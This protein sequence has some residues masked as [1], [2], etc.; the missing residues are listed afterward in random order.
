LADLTQQFSNLEH[1]EPGWTKADPKIK[2]KT[3]GTPNPPDPDVAIAAIDDAPQQDIQPTFSVSKRALKVFNTLFH[4]PT[5]ADHAGEIPWTD[6]L[7]AMASTGFSIE[8][9]YGSVWQFTPSRLDVEYPISFHE[10]HP[11]GKIAFRTARRIGR[12]LQRAYGWEGAM[13]SSE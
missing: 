3:K 8:K 6:F 12:R 2:P 11:A 7:H 5:V 4:T 10:P 13:F 1:T 9:L